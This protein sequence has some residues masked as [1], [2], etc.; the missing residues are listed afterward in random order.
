[1]QYI[2]A[3]VFGIVQGIT[4]FLPISSSGHL[5]ILHKFI[6][7]PLQNE[8]AFDVALHLATLFAVIFFFYSD[9]KRLFLSWIENLPL[10]PSL[11]K[12]GNNVDILK[13]KD[14]EY[15][16]ISWLI[17]LA[18]IPAGLAGWFFEDIVENSLRSPL[19]VAVM[20][21]VV[22]ALFIIFEKISKK[23]DNLKN[24]NWKKS[25]IIG[26]AQAIALIP[27]TSRSGITIIAGLGAGLKRQAAIRFSFLLSIPVILGA[28]ATKIPQIIESGL[29]INELVILAIAFIA[30]FVSGILAIKYFLRFAEK[31]SL[32]TFAFYRFALAVV[33][34]VFLI[35]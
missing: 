17:I 31:H 11:L 26:L 25:L 9:I 8:M 29:A 19:V 30:S 32:N 6:N 18:T 21:I 23:T 22:G 16:K 2:Y 4:E 20:L 14:Y 10:T 5:V 35:F 12:R 13:K 24:L 27:G 15:S 1:M 34:I 33:I 28:S 3:I 7:L